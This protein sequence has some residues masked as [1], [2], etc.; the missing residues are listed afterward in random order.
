M[1]SGWK[2]WYHSLL[3]LPSKTESAENFYTTKRLLNDWEE[4]CRDAPKGISAFPPTDNLNIWHVR[5]PSPNGKPLEATVIFNESYPFQPPEVHFSAKLYHPNI[6]PSG[7]VC[8]KKE[9]WSPAHTVWSL[10]GSVQC[11]LSEP[12]PEDALNVTA[13]RMMLRN[14][15]MYQHLAAQCFEKAEKYQR[16]EQNQK[17][18]SKDNAKENEEDMMT[19]VEEEL[20]FQSQLAEV[21]ASYDK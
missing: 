2:V 3:P 5:I 20:F 17:S 6:D 12:N 13:A 18:Y 9:D 4:L 8:I 15:T 1:T 11:L 19:E 7:K 10:L 14:P 21:Y 16:S